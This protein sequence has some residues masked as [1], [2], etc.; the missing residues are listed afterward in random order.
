MGTDQKLL[1]VTNLHPLPW[2]PNHAS[3][4]AQ[5]FSRLEQRFDLARII[6]I[7]WFQWWKHRRQCINTDKL[8]YLPYFY[9]PKIGRRLY[10]WFQSLSLILC[11]KWIK[12][13]SPDAVL[14]SWGY[15]DAVAVQKVLA[16]MEI[17]FFIKVHG[18]DINEN[19]RHPSRQQKI[20]ASMDK[21]TAVFCPSQALS[22]VLT[23]AGVA[24]SKTKVIYNGV[25]KTIFY[26]ADSCNNSLIF[27]G[28]IIKTKGVEELYQAF[29][30]LSERHKA[31]TLTLVGNGDLTS[32]LKKRVISDK[33]ADRVKFTGSLPLTEVAA[34]IRNARLLVLPSYREGLPNVLLEA[35]ASGTPVV[36][37]D[38]GGIP[39]IVSPQS[40]VYTSDISPQ[41]LSQ[42]IE[43]ALSTQWNKKELE[44]HASQFDWELNANKVSQHIKDAM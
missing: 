27:V 18:T 14:A 19:I 25:D 43:Q 10:P 38:V 26:P 16:D 13:F 1:I 5:Q 22:K 21:A 6:L 12:R 9:I 41:N 37:S 39:E 44:A 35:F 31:L 34:Q 32:S 36:A 28:N 33:L 17:P 4:N 29:Q 3:F 42:T 15:P 20:L 30:L 23:T 2:A 40:G 11:R 8:L 24:E 7:P